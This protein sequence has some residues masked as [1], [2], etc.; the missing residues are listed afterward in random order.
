V[1]AILEKELVNSLKLLRNGNDKTKIGESLLDLSNGDQDLTVGLSFISITSSW[2]EF[3]KENQF[4][5]LNEWK[6]SW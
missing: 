1:T 4:K 3:L 6:N 5:K 2:L